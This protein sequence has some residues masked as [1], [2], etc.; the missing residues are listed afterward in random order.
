M[1]P[2]TVTVISEDAAL[3][4]MCREALRDLGQAGAW[5]LIAAANCP[6]STSGICLWDYDPATNSSPNLSAT[7]GA[8]NLFLVSPKDLDQ[9]YQLVP[10]A[11]GSI[12]LK[13][14]TRAVL[15]AFL[16]SVAPGPA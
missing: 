3:I 2:T 13:P 10:R 11:E 7:S 6:P 8:I 15:Q 1:Q 9:F 14:V 16:G 5:Q 12:L 4:M